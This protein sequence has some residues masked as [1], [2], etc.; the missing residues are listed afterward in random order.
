[1][2]R[3]TRPDLRS[4]WNTAVTGGG[5]SFRQGLRG[6]RRRQCRWLHLAAGDTQGGARS[7]LPDSDA[8]GGRRSMRLGCWLASAHLPCAAGSL[9]EICS[10]SLGSSGGGRWAAAKRFSTWRKR[11]ATAGHDGAA[12]RG[13]RGSGGRRRGAGC[14]GI[15]AAAAGDSIRWRLGRSSSA[16]TRRAH[17]KDARSPGLKR[18]PHERDSRRLETLAVAGSERGYAL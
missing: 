7:F 5:C 3:A 9:R 1:M 4:T 18:L 13:A 15:S 11:R 6:R 17:G 10:R 12:G 16:R 14:L 2:T 8:G